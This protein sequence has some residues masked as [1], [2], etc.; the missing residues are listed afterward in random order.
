MTKKEYEIVA[1]AVRYAR[2]V[3]QDLSNLGVSAAH[4]ALD[5]FVHDFCDIAKADN[6]RFD[7][8]YFLK[9]TGTPLNRFD[10]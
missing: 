9:A 6:P 3:S 1:S 2:P 5:M 8:A 10:R 7:R 4:H